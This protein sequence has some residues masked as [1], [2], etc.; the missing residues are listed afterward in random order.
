[1]EVVATTESWL[2]EIIDKLV[3]IDGYNTF[4]KGRV[5]GRDGGVC[6]CVYL[7]RYTM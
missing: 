6:V 5:H 4:R 1:M 3:L 7:S 2:M